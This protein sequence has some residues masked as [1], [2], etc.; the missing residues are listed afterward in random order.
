MNGEIDPRL[1]GEQVA[2]GHI[3]EARPSEPTQQAEPGADEWKTWV[4]AWMG[5][6]D[7]VMRTEAYDELIAASFAQR[8]KQGADERNGE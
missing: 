2:R 1:F 4:D 7:V 8:G 3:R 5:R 6:Q